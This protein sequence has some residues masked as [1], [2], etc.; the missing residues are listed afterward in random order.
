MS[1]QLAT[2]AATI[3]ELEVTGLII[4]DADEIP[5]EVGLRKP[6][7]MIPLPNIVTDFSM[8][9]DSF[10]GGSTAKMTVTYYMNYRLLYEPVGENRAKT[11]KVFDGLMKMIGLILDA[12]LVIDVFNDDHTEVIDI[13]PMNVTNMGIVNDPA[14]RSFYGADFQFKIEEFVN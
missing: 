1:I 10:G 4:K 5:T 9:R 11:L 6:A 12:V 2:V 3:A 13:V 14:D 8:E 7:V